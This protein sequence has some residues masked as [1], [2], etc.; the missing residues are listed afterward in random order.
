MGIT[1]EKIS[2]QF[3]KTYYRVEIISFREP[4]KNMIISEFSISWF[5]NLLLDYFL[6][7]L[8]LMDLLRDKMRN[9]KP[10]RLLRLKPIVVDGALLKLNV[11][12]NGADH[13]SA[14]YVSIFVQN[15]NS[16][17]L[18]L[19]TEFRM[20]E[21]NINHGRKVQMPNW[22]SMRVSKPDETRKQSS[23]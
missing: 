20:K 1:K 2:L 5:K 3:G 6:I 10:G 19:D 21:Q 14:G 17:D 22:F 9:W 11:Y 12:P 13:T 18:E 23:I 16:E 7:S 15:Q 4:I 8:F